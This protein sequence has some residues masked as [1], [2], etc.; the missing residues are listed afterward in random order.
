MK[1][2]AAGMPIAAYPAIDSS[3]SRKIEA[4]VRPMATSRHSTFRVRILP[5][6]N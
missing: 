1:P 4:C 6:Q 2:T 3:Q 5:K